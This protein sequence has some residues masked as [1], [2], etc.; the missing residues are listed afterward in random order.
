VAEKLGERELI[1][2]AG[3]FDY[4]D[5]RMFSRISSVLF[6]A[7]VPGGLLAIGNVAAQNPSRWVMEYFSEWFLIHRT[8]EQLL[9][10]VDDLEPTPQ[11]IMVD[12]EPSGV[13]LFLLVRR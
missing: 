5:T 9:A 3:L 13:N 8:P 4:L 11:Q 7:L 6:E 2:S 1:Y 12:A 10:L